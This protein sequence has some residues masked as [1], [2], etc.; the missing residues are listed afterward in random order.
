MKSYQ[1]QWKLC[2]GHIQRSPPSVVARDKRKTR[3]S[4]GSTMKGKKC[5]K[6]SNIPA[7]LIDAVS[8]G[9]CLTPFKRKA[10]YSESNL[11]NPSFFPLLLDPLSF[12]YQVYRIPGTYLAWW[13]TKKSLLSYPRFQIR[14]CPEQLIDAFY[15]SSA[16]PNFAL[17]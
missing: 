4:C 8:C 15:F 2:H 12:S 3:R 17:V 16:F 9:Y 11:R 14:I 7:S 5:K 13:Y 1:F 10:S 6:Y